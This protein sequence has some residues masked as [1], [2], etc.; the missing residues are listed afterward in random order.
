MNGEE[1]R[2]IVKKRNKVEENEKKL[3][4]NYKHNAEETENVDQPEEEELTHLNSK[5]NEEN[6]EGIEQL[7]SQGNL[8]SK[9]DIKEKE[10]FDSQKQVTVFFF[11]FSSLF[12]LSYCSS[13]ALGFFSACL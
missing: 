5:I 13:S 10:Y 12:F 9:E 11:F 2:E 4:G 3:N 6:S 1:S 8:Q 7:N